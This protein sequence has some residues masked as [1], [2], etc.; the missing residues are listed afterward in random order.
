MNSLL[1]LTIESMRIFFKRPLRDQVLMHS[2]YVYSE[3]FPLR[4]ILAQISVPG[5]DS[6]GSGIML[7][8]RGG[9]S[10][11]IL[12]PQQVA[13]L[14]W[15]QQIPSSLLS[16]REREWTRK[17]PLLSN[18]HQLEMHT[19]VIYWS[20]IPPHILP[21]WSPIPPHITQQTALPF[22]PNRSRKKL[23]LERSHQG[24]VQYPFSKHLNP[25]KSKTPTLWQ[26]TLQGKATADERFYSSL[27]TLYKGLVSGTVTRRTCH[28]LKKKKK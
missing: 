23:T 15:A 19:E 14:H 17:L 16:P 1:S 7:G 22:L 10:H 4:K 9:G 2:K 18:P 8:I 13:G 27:F 25:L 5:L 6:C 24:Q 3:L 12:G 20:P 11:S 21:Y 28:F 26:L